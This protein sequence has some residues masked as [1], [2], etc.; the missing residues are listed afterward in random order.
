MQKYTQKNFF[1]RR[2]ESA[3]EGDIISADEALAA[4]RFGENGLL[5]VV[6]QCADSQQVLM[7]AWMNRE[8]LQKTLTS[9]RMTYYS[10]SRRQLWQKGETSGNSQELLSLTADCD[11]DTLLACVRQ[12]N[13]ACHSG[14]R[15]CFYV[16]LSPTARITAGN[17]GSG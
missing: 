5:P 2:L 16:Q 13:T 11:G 8:A 10:R 15:S 14:R 17:K 9:G 12:I 1:W 3:G 7:L 4:L 6:T